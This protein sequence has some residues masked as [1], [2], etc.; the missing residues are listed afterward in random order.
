MPCATPAAIS[1]SQSATAWAEAALLE[2]D[3]R[4]IGRTRHGRPV[5][6]VEAFKPGSALVLGAVG[7][8]GARERIRQRLGAWGLVETHDFW[9]VA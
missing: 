5:I 6:P 4:K 2:I 7:A 8:R 3:K 9:M 1:R